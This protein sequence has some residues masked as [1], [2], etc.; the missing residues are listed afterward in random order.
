MAKDDGIDLTNVGI[1]NAYV[2]EKF[3]RGEVVRDGN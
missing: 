2:L 3:I 1:D